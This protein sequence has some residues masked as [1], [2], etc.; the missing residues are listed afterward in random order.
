MNESDKILVELREMRSELT[1]EIRIKNDDT[2]NR[3][4]DAMAPL[5][6]KVAA[7]DTEI[8]DQRAKVD[9][10]DRD[11]QMLRQRI[12]DETIREDYSRYTQ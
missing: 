10:L 7:H 1:K 3:V 6:Q 8:A 11:I 5:W 2:V 9:K 4:V 12:Y